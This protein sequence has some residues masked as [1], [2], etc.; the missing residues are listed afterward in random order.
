MSCMMFIRNNKLA[1]MIN[2]LVVMFGMILIGASTLLF[3]QDLLNPTQWMILVGLGLYLAYVPFNS[4]FFERLIAAFEY[5]GTVGFV[6]YLADSFG[7][8]GSIGVLFFK[9]FGFAKLSW[10]S[11]FV[12]SGYVISIAGS[13]LVAASMLYF[14]LKYSV[15]NRRQI[16]TSTVS[17]EVSLL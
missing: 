17:A 3:E 7:Y 5:V 8:L 16:P 14:H 2:H 9:E 13:V 10:L 1:L 6:M 15:W 12:S 11:F 4:I